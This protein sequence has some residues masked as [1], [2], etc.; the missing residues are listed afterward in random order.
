MTK[1][2]EPLDDDV[3]EWRESTMTKSLEPRSDDDDV[4]EW[5]ES[6]MTKSL[7][8]LDLV[9]MTSESGKSQQ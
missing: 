7:E 9:M 8:P 3:R 5:R 4:R 2:L 6:T 1:S